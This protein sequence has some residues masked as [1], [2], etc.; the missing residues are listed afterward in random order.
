MFRRGR[1]EGAVALTQVF[2]GI[3]RSQLRR[4]AGKRLDFRALGVPNTHNVL[5]CRISR[6]T[7]RGVVAS[8]RTQG[9]LIGFT[10]GYAG[11]HQAFAA[12]YTAACGAV[13]QIR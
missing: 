10:G 11:I 3:S 7:I 2:V 4:R 9:V 5:R 12:T 8:R 6:Y 13:D 1:N